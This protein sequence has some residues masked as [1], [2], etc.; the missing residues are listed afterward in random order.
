MA[1]N[2]KGRLRVAKSFY[3]SRKIRSL[4]FYVN[5]VNCQQLVRVEHSIPVISA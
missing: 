5:L 4:D 3:L 1:A 2:V